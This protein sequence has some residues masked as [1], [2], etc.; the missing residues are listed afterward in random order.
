MNS[1]LT[2]LRYAW[3]VK[4][5]TEEDILLANQLVEKD[6]EVDENMS[7]FLTIQHALNPFSPSQHC[8]IDRH[9]TL[10]KGQSIDAQPAKSM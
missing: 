5:V 3:Q 9:R 6:K 10:H 2:L 4:G 1:L 8:L 7:T